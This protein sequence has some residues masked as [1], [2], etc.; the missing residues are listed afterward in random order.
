V[1]VEDVAI[2]QQEEIGDGT[3]SI[4]P[5]EH[6]LTQGPLLGLDEDVGIPARFIPHQVAAGQLAIVFQGAARLNRK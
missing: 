6:E 1:P 4:G 2:H 5:D 3:W